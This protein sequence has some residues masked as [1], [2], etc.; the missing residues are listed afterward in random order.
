MGSLASSNPP[1][2]FSLAA[3]QRADS[4]TITIESRPTPVPTRS[5]V[6]VRLYASGVCATDLHLS[7]R[8][9]PFLTPSVVVGG[10][11]G[12]GNIAALGPDVDASA[13]KL[14]DRVA[15]RWLNSVCQT[16]EVCTTGFENLCPSRR[17][18]GKDVEG[19]FGEYA[20]AESR[21]MVRLPDDVDFIE[22][23]PILCAGVTVYKA[24]KVAALAQ[25]SWV[26]IS[27]AGGGLGHLGIQYAKAMGLRVLALDA[28]KREFCLDLGADAYVDVLSKDVDV[29]G[30]AVK[31]T[32]GGAHGALVCA[33]VGKAYVD[34]VK[35]LRRAG[36]LVCVGIPESKTQIPVSPEDFVGRGIRVVGTSTGSLQDT[37]EAL[38]YVAR[39]QVKTEVLLRRLDQ[40]G[41]VLDEIEGGKLRGKA[42]I[43]I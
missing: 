4:K 36:T 40:V 20:L 37:D 5:Q 1:P 38:R 25:G 32:G 23:A 24:L 42:V 13:W 31:V 33:S 34:A 11:E 2:E 30:Q 39:G 3:I 29:V 26:A 16:C 19:C 14:N 28:G 22:A 6:L 41:E 17:I 10:H 7:R 8:T 18:T 27:G 43:S 12:V 9:I 21:Y 15:V 35:Y